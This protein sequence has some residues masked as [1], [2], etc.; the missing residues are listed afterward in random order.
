[1]KVEVEMTE[2]EAFAYAQREASKAKDDSIF[3]FNEGCRSF[4]RL[5]ERLDRIDERMALLM[6]AINV[7]KK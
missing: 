2:Q 5:F 1:M 3:H 4:A 6:S 7:I